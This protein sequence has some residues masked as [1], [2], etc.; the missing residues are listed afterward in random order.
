MLE[1]T[2]LESDLA[3]CACGTAELETFE[4]EEF[5]VS[6]DSFVSFGYRFLGCFNLF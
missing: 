6:F 1:L 2:V 5:G 4:E 3:Y